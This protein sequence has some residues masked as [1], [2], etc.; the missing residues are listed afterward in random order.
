MHSSIGTRSLAYPVGS[1]VMDMRS[2][3]KDERKRETI[4]KSR[5]SSIDNNDNIENSCD[6]SNNSHDSSSCI[7]TPGL[8]SS[9]SSEVGRK[10]HR[11]HFI[12]ETYIDF[13]PL[14]VI[15]LFDGGEHENDF[16]PYEDEIVDV[17]RTDSHLEVYKD[18]RN[19]ARMSDILAVYA[20]VDPAT[21][22]CQGMIDLLSPFVMLFEDNAEAFWCFEMLIRRL[23]ENF[24]M[25]GPSRVMKQLQ[26]LW[27]I[28]KHTDREMFAHL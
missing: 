16:V 27:H 25:E 7:P 20:W 15:D 17:L 22:Y 23:R 12:T 8:Y 5:Q 28:L 10:Y 24:Q 2:S 14:P 13:L 26:A 6:L 21:G 1:K 9:S 3:S 19:L 11:P 18:T 4:V